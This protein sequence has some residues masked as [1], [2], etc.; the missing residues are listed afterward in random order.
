MTVKLQKAA[1]VFAAATLSFFMLIF[2]KAVQRGVA[3]GLDIAVTR[4][5]PS[6]FLFTSAAIFLS[7][8]LADNRK[9]AVKKDLVGASLTTFLL[10]LVSGYPVGAR[11]INGL[12]RD[13]AVTRKRAVKM[14]VYS[15]NAGPAFI[16]SAVG[17]RV[18]GSKSDGIRLFI[19]LTIASMLLAIAVELLPSRF[20]GVSNQNFG[21]FITRMPKAS[22]NKRYLTD[23]FVESV[24]ESG[25]TMLSICFFVIFF[26]GIGALLKEIPLP[27]SDAFCQLLEVTVGIKGCT[28]K[29]LEKAAFLMGF[30]GVSV[31]FQVAAAARDVRPPL[32]SILLGR[33]AHGALAAALVYCAEKLFPRSIQTGNFGGF[34]MNAVGSSGPLAAVAMMILAVVLLD[35]GARL[36]Y[37]INSKMK[38]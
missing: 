33:M 37:N 20:W 5:V 10:S 36:Y 7:K 16:I 15:T 4:I 18:L 6:L 29:T 17:E 28:R 22:D 13:G 24:M 14:C 25:Q 9:T 23:I 35:S 19:C 30:G 31:I 11:L 2:S 26:A 34:S 12:Y 3:M 21:P 8:I 27:F 1:T 38:Y 32:K